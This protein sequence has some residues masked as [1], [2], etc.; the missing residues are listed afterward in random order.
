MTP[1][2]IQILLECHCCIHPGTNMIDKIWHSEAAITC[3]SWLMHENLIDKN[4]R[5]TE[6]GKALVA[7]LCNLQLPVATGTIPGKPSCE[8]G[9]L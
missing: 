6:R 8:V 2:D 1:L 5:T 7:A 3:R 9:E 4:S